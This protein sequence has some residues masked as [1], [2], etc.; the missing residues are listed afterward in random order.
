[1]NFQQHDNEDHIDEGDEEEPTQQDQPQPSSWYHA[2]EEWIEHVNKVSQK[3]C[4]HPGWAVAID[5][6][7]QKFMGQSAET[8]R[9]NLKP[10]KE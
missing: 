2:V 5:E 8:I 7:L 10:D 1:M 6:M 4:K 9:L 3:L